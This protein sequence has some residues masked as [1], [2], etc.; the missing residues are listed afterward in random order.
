MVNTI[1]GKLLYIFF[2]FGEK[3][4][5]SLGKLF[6]YIKKCEVNEL[7]VVLNGNE[8]MIEQNM[9]LTAF[10]E[11]KGMDFTTIIVEYNGE[12]MKQEVWAS[13]MLE[14]DDRLEV[15][16]FVGGG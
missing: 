2:I 1:V 5:P 14:N 13:V 7:K 8:E 15:L 11:S 6:C 9:N 16:K 12:I 4:L 3:S 10:L